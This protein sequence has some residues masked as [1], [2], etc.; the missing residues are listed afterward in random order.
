MATSAR[1]ISTGRYLA[2]TSLV[3]VAFIAG[4]TGLIFTVFSPTPPRTVRMA[5]NPQGSYSA[6]VA[7]QYRDLLAK[8]G[9]DLKL[10]PSAGAVQ[11]LALLQDAKS[12]VSIA[13]IPSGITNEYKSPELTSLGA[14]FYEPLWCF[15]KSK[16]I[17][18]YEDLAGLNISIGPEGSGAHALS[19]E[20]LARVGIVN[21]KS[22]KLYSWPAEKAG[23][24]LLNG[25]INAAILLDTFEAPVV[26]ELLTAKDVTVNSE[27]RADAFVALYPFLSKLTLP[28][29]AADMKNNRPPNDVILLATEAN[30]VVRNDLHPA[31]Q[32]RL[33]EAASHIHS[34]ARLFQTAARFPAPE[35]ND[36]S[37]SVHA[38][39]FFKTGP[40]FLQRHLPFWLAVL[41]QQLLVL[42]IPIVGVAYPILQFS[43]QIYDWMQQR[44]IYTLY[45]E[46]AG[47]E[48]DM[49]SVSP[50]F[51]SKGLI[52]CLDQLEHRANQL[53]VPQP[54]L[55]LLYSLK[56]HIDMVRQQIGDPG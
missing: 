9:I 37:L 4:L 27:A 8:D 51:D 45:S 20:L 49:V 50:R 14:L 1:R 22:A 3:L 30:L 35:A 38:R 19:E 7:R 11:S 28:A 10:I 48:A 31:I 12:G 21:E 29:G 56:S 39:Q 32:Y 18:T 13:I 6:E 33:L 34:R 2:L 24:A 26:H 16:V 36:L 42:L 15:S 25:E 55:P 44:R 40:P 52:E 41:V 5:V 23:A 54:Y 53:S 46:L 43:P 47:I 17:R